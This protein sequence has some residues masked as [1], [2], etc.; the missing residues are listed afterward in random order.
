MNTSRMTAAYRYEPLARVHVFE[1]GAMPWHD[2]PEPGLRLK[3]VRYDDETGCSPARSVSC[4]CRAAA[5]TSTSVCRGC[6]G[7]WS[8]HANAPN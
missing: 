2:T 8:I 5:F 6:K 7:R 3:P 4:R 1:A